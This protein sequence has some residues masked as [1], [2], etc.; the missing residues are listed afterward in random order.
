MLS[1]SFILY[2]SFSHYHLCLFSSFS[3]LLASVYSAT[4]TF[5]PLMLIFT[6]SRV[7]H[8]SDN[9]TYKLSPSFLSFWYQA[10]CEWLL[11]CRLPHSRFPSLE[12]GEN[13]TEWDIARKWYLEGCYSESWRSGFLITQPIYQHWRQHPYRSIFVGTLLY[14]RFMNHWCFLSLH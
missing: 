12:T 3:L 13:K 10:V 7:S 5:L 2:F 4:N 8:S 14:H 9:S 6:H 1:C 11:F